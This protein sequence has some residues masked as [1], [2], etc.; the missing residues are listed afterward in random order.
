MRPWLVTWG[1]QRFDY[2][3]IGD[4]VNLAARLESASKTLGHTL[5]V[6]EATKKVIDD[7]F[8]FEF[9]DSITVKG[10]TEP[11]NVYTLTR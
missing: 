9:V 4:P 10:K 5:I 8:T 11:V 7:K 2:S 3:V 1:D 6:G